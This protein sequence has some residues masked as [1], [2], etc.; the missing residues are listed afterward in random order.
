MSKLIGPLLSISARGKFGSSL[1][2]TSDCGGPHVKKLVPATGEPTAKQTA[3]RLTLKNASTAWFTYF[4]DADEIAAWNLAAK[5]S[6]SSQSGY[7]A[8]LGALKQHPTTGE[9]SAFVDKIDWLLAGNLTV[10]L[11][12]AYSGYR[13][14]GTAGWQLW[15]GTKPD[16]LLLNQTKTV[17]T[18]KCYFNPTYATG[19][20]FYFRIKKTYWRS[21]IYAVTWPW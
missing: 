19:T 13:P 11:L 7:N 20:K 4:H 3:A 21:G 1:V 6:G 15:T 9:E 18:G 17:T 12:R 16:N 14:S 2:F 5:Y 8:F 10:W